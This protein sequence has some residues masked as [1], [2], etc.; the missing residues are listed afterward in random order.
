[1]SGSSHQI[2]L[3]ANPL[4]EGA[5]TGHGTAPEPSLPLPAPIQLEIP[6][7]VWALGIDEET[8]P[9][10]T[11]C[12]GDGGGGPRATGVF[13]VE[14]IVTDSGPRLLL[15]TPPDRSARVNGAPVPCVGLLNDGDQVLLDG[16]ASLHVAFVRRLLRQ[17]AE[18]RHTARPC[19]VCRGQI[20]EGQEIYV[21][22]CEA[23]MH[24]ES[25]EGKGGSVAHPLVASPAL[26]SPALDP[27][28]GPEGDPAGEPLNCAS[29]LPEC[30]ACKRA[31]E[32]RAT[33]SPHSGGGS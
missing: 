15:L 10:L 21:C 4:F 5:R 18:T 16:L 31:I 28:I 13:V 33:G 2:L 29:M 19:V 26:V 17:P 6:G 7:G 3:C 1:M 32:W 8:T 14:P 12:P 24:C 30:P 23:V 20:V 11:P 22:A 25:S 9:R 27:V